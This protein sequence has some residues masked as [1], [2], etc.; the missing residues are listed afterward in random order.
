MASAGVFYDKA[1]KAFKASARVDG[2]PKAIGHFKNEED[3]AKA[4]DR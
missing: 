1:R 2:R 3:A 4:Y